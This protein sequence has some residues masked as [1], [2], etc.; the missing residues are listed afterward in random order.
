M[1]KY[2]FLLLLLS[3]L[4]SYGQSDSIPAFKIFS[5]RA[6][7]EISWDELLNQLHNKDVIFFG[8]EHNDSVAH[9]L[10]LRLL[11][12]LHRQGHR[13]VILSME[14]FQSDVQLVLNEY[15]QGL[16]SERNF[17]T[18]ARV[19]NNYK[20]YRPLV[21]Y[22]KENNLPVS[23][24]NAPDRYVNL[25]ARKGLSALQSLSK[26]ARG[27]LPPLP[28]DTLGGRYA[29]KFHTLMGGHG[30]MGSMRLYQAQNLWDATMAWHI[31]RLMKRRRKTKQVLHLT[32]RFHSDEKLG[33]YA[34][35]MKYGH[36]LQCTN[37]SVFNDPAFDHPQWDQWT[38]LGDYIIVTRPT[39]A[40]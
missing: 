19:W 4:L 28:I 1:I 12:G 8:E 26:E 32:G 30:G 27:F 6:Q 16:I 20:D 21:A 23:A 17:A 35:L 13:Q 5:V 37:L 29:E 22:A 18:A 7:R 15:L 34:Q 10:E 14:M 40:P 38:E 9:V 39:H 33:T 3:P 36:K 11:K 25:V 31:A 24:A 2:V